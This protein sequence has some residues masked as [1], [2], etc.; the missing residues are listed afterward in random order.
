MLAR[1]WRGRVPAGKSEAYL[2]YLHETG[3]KEYQATEGN[4]GV[5]ILQRTEAGITEFL[6]LTLWDSME[7]IQRFAGEEVEKPVYY[8][9]DKNFLLEFEPRVYHYEVEAHS[10]GLILT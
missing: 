3:V 1:I 7:A 10:K 5:Y 8:P 9:E 2:E 4:Q 6:I